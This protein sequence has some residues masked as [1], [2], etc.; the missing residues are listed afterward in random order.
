[1]SRWGAQSRR[2]VLK[3]TIAALGALGAPGLINAATG[4]RSEG[5]DGRARAC[6][7]L[8]MD[9]APSHLDIWDLKPDAPAEIRG[10]FRPIETTIPG[11]RIVEHLPRVARQMH[12]LA[13]IRSVCHGES[14]HP[15]ALYHVLTGFRLPNTSGDPDVRLHRH[16]HVGT[17]V[18]KLTVPAGSEPVVVELPETMA[19][20]GPPMA[21]QDAGF[22]GSAYDPFRVR[23]ALESL[24]VDRPGLEL[25]P[26]VSPDRMLRRRKLTG[27]IENGHAC[28]PSTWTALEGLQC[29]AL[30][31]LT[32]GRL[33]AAF[34]LDREPDAVRQSYGRHRH[35]QCVL[36]ARRLVEAGVRFVGV[37]W[38]REPQDWADGVKGRVANNP[39]DTHRNHFP[40]LKET[41]LPRADQALSALVEDLQARGLLPE[42]LVVW[43]GEFGRTP[44]ISKFASRDHWPGA[45]SVVM[46]GGGVAPGIVLGRTDATASEVTDDPVAPPDILATIYRLMGIDP[47]TAVVDRLG[48]SHPLTTGRPIEALLS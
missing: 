14:V 37:N 16:P 28:W 40:L 26:G 25:P 41:L 19:L 32:S 13:L 38:G 29:Q 1:M 44:R 34:D 45:Y 6:I 42:V 27:A 9:G 46:A 17:L 11:V 48:R 20:D 36:L 3:H 30:E 12:R 22:L 33:R 47:V 10:P 31:V 4:P 15:P 35:G 43:M 23:V 2:A 18:G 39:W 21:G 24:V 7:L 5:P 8:F